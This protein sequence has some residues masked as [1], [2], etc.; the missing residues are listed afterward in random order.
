MEEHLHL[1]AW[2]DPAMRQRML[3]TGPSSEAHDIIAIQEVRV[4][5]RLS[6]PLPFRVCPISSST[7]L[8]EALT[9]A[10]GAAAPVS[11]L[12]NTLDEVVRRRKARGDLGCINE[13]SAAAAEFECD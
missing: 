5:F 2:R 4:L 9:S 1:K 13:L 12:P 10:C 7:I 11:G 8:L 6:T 3:Q